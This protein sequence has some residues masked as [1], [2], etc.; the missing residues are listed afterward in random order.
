MYAQKPERGT[1][2][3]SLGFGEAEDQPEEMRDHAVTCEFVDKTSWE[4]EVQWVVPL[5]TSFILLKILPGRRCQ[6]ERHT[7]P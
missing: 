1:L 2:S 7:C 3:R 6:A 5:I 4:V